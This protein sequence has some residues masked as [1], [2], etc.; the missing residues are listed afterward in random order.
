MHDEDPLDWRTNE[1]IAVNEFRTHGLATTTFLTLFPFGKGDP[2]TLARQHGVTLTEAFKHLVKFAER[3]PNGKYRWR[4]A[5]H[6]RLPYWASDMK[7]RHQFLS[8]SNAYLHQ[9]P[10]DAHMTIKVLREM[11]NS[12]SGKQMVN[13][14]QR[15][16]SKVQCT[17]AYWYQ[18]LQELL[19]LIE[20]KGCP[21]FF[22]TFSAADTYWPEL[23][24][25]SRMRKMLRGQNEGK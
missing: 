3:L 21:T 6:P 1:G 11:V 22:V 19:T 8:Q 25:F 4:F 23:Q 15:Y 17:N 18:R 14:L 20:R 5:S 7:Q 2:T 13:W 12:M 10:A 9:H 16:V 24:R